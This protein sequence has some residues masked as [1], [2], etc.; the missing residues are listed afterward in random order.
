MPKTPATPEMRSLAEPLGGV[1][2]RDAEAPFGSHPFTDP[3]YEIALMML[4]DFE[5][6]RNAQGLGFR[7]DLQII[8]NLEPGTLVE[9]AGQ[10]FCI[11]IHFGVGERIVE[12][13]AAVTQLLYLGLPSAQAMPELAR[14]GSHFLQSASLPE[15][16]ADLSSRHLVNMQRLLAPLID[17]GHGP[18]H[19]YIANLLL[20]FVILKQ[21]RR[22]TD[23]FCLYL[24]EAS[25]A[26]R[27]L[28]HA[29][30]DL[31]TDSIA[32]ATIAT[33][34]LRG[35]PFFD[36]D[37]ADW[38]QIERLEAFGLGVLLL[39]N[40]AS[41]PAGLD[42]SSTDAPLVLDR[43]INFTYLPERIIA[44]MP[45]AAEDVT[46]M[47]G[48]LGALLYALAEA[49]PAFRRLAAP[50]S[51]DALTRHERVVERLSSAGEV[52]RAQAA[53]G[54]LAFAPKRAS[55]PG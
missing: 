8:D 39:A 1:L 41:D 54:R 12:I 2:V 44:N 22:A 45:E 3:A 23:G 25:P 29:Y 4:A 47:Q 48:E 32:F 16:P 21:I 31:E 5:G 51:S 6:S 13:A 14:L 42:L 19:V 28:L 9:Y 55:L 30:A 34:L 26:D 10:R 7:S 33:N 18:K 37:A 46:I 15:D 20:L 17:A 52:Q 50:L 38:S 35:L 49:D 40:T 36:V 53:L 43:I 11:G 27:P 24:A